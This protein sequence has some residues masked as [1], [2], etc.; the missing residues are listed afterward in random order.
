MGKLGRGAEASVLRV[1]QFDRGL[2][3]FVDQLRTQRARLSRKRL[4]LADRARHALGGFEHV[5]MFFLVSLG[6]R[7][8]NALEAGTPLMIVWRKIRTAVEGLAFRSKKRGKRPATLSADGL[9]RRL[10]TAVHVRTLVAVD[11]DGDEILVD[12]G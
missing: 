9:H 10:V 5:S 12:D 3:D 7:Q 2:R 4:R 8:Q 6:Q 11:F 1:K